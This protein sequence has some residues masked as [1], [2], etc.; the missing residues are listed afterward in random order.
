MTNLDYQDRLNNT[1]YTYRSKAA[2]AR[3]MVM[4]D[5][6]NWMADRLEDSTRGAEAKR[7]AKDLAH[8]IVIKK[9]YYGTLRRQ[10]GWYRYLKWF[11]VTRW[12]GREP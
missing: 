5:I 3:S 11:Y 6:Y 2:D 8:K 10:V 12:L 1:I 7:G 4:K 9:Q